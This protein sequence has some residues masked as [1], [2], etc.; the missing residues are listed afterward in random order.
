MSAASQQRRTLAGYVA[1]LFGAALVPV[2]MVVAVVAW[3]QPAAA[4]DPDDV[5]QSLTFQ[6]TTLATAALVVGTSA[7]IAVERFIG[8]PL[9]GLHQAALRIHAGDLAARAGLT[10]GPR[11]LADLSAAFDH[12][13]ASLE[14]REQR[15]RR[16]EEALRALSQQLIDVQEKDRRA[17]ARELHDEIGQTLTAIT[18][19]L[20]LVR[21]ITSDAAI[22]ARVADTLEL[23]DRTLEQVRDLSLDLRPPMLDHLGLVPALRWLL[24]RQGERA[25]FTTELI[26]GPADLQV[27]D[28]LSIMCFRIVQEAV[29]NVARHAQ[30]RHV[31][32]ELA[33]RGQHLEVSIADDGRGFDVGEARARV[34]VGGGA[35]LLG[36][37]ERATLAGGTLSLD[38]TSAGTIVRATLPLG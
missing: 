2:A 4:L 26:A 18:L 1:L 33:R 37:E 35:G 30:A 9:R 15:W 19:N 11:E 3:W 21:E 16:H 10:R 38:S 8:G 34:V 5:A 7:W 20:Q 13:A 22:Q 28:A 24:D 27:P 32:V 23:A 6:A 25:G 29:T 12:M 31:R 36:M 14:A 17:I